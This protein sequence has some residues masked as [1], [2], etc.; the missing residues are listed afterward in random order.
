MLFVEERWVVYVCV[1]RA[2]CRARGDGARG[3]TR[4]KAQ[5]YRKMRWKITRCPLTR[6]HRAELH[7]LTNSA[8]ERGTARRRRVERER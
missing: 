6:K 8:G 7:R 5:N 3:E 4:L 1:C 2:V